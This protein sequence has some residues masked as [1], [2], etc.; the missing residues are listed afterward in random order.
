MSNV[1]NTILDQ[2]GGNK[3]CFMTGAKNFATDGKALTFQIMRNASGSNR[4]KITL[5]EKDL[6]DVEFGNIRKFEYKVRKSFT[7]IYCE[8]LVRIFEQTT[9][10]YTTI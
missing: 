5:N 10:L 3:F 4:V 8:D 6:Y 1:A 9:K 2:L 7:D